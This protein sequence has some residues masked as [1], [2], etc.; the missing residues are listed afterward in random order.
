MQL[1]HL[2]QLIYLILEQSHLYRGDKQVNF[3][4]SKLEKI[5]RL[6][7]HSSFYRGTVVNCLLTC[8]KDNIC[9]IWC[10]TIQQ[11]ESAI[12][13]NDPTTARTQRK[14]QHECID[15]SVQKLHKLR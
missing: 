5:A 6:N 8:C 10:E 12:Y 7:Q 11:D 13:I 9:R 2:H 14:R 15:K 1:H 3:F 4:Q